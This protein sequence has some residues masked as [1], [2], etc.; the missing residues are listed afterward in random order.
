MHYRLI[1]RWGTW[2]CYSEWRPDQPHEDWSGSL[3]AHGGNLYNP[4]Q[5]L[6][7]GCWGAQHRVAVELPAPE[8]RSPLLEFERPVYGYK[9]LEGLRIDVEGDAETR[10]SFRS[11]ML[12]A[13]FR[14][15][16]IPSGDRLVYAAG[17]KYSCAQLVICR[18]E[19]EGIYWN[20][21][22]FAASGARDGRRRL[23]LGLPDMQGTFLPREL[24]HRES[25]WI[26][27][28]AEVSMPF[29]WE[30]DSAAVVTWRFTAAPW[31]PLSESATYENVRAC[32]S[33][34]V[35]LLTALDGEPL[36]HAELKAKYMRGAFSALEHVDELG[37]AGRPGPRTLAIRN[38]SED[39]VYLVLHG[40]TIEAPP[41]HWPTTRTHLPFRAEW[42]DGTRP[43]RDTAADVP[44]GGKGL[45]L[46]F[47]TN[48]MAAENGWIDAA[49]RY[50]A[51]TAAGN[52]VLFRT[53]SDR[54]FPSDWRRMFTACRENGIYFAVNVDTT[55]A[56]PEPG[57]PAF[58]L[59]DLIALAAELGG[60]RFV[61]MKHHELSLPL[62]AGRRGVDWPA[63][64][65]VA[66]AEQ[67][68]L[69]EVRAAYRTGDESVPR[70][71]GEAML[72][73]RY[74]YKAGVDL[75]LSETMTG[76]TSLLLAEARGAA[77]AYA[78]DFWGLHIACHVNTSPEDFRHERMYW[79]NLA[80]GYLSGA[81]LIEDEEGGLAKVHSFVSGPSDPLPAERQAST[82]RFFR[83]AAEHPRP[84]FPEVDIG[85]LY[86]RHE[87]IT[88][89]MSL[90]PQRPVR[91]W[92]GF[93]PAAPEWEYGRPERGWLLADVFLP[94]VWLC[95]VL[96]DA[97]TLRRWFAGT[98]H[99]QVDVVPIEADAA[100]LAA[101]RFLLMPG[102]HTMQEADM[103]TLAAWVN[104]GGTL[105]LGLAQLQVSDDRTTVIRDGAVRF[106]PA[107]AVERLCGL[108]I[109]GL[110]PAEAGTEVALNRRRFCLTHDEDGTPTLAN[111]TLGAASK[112][113]L[114][115]G[116]RPL[117]VEHRLG[118]GRVYTW[119]T[120]DYFGHGGLLPLV[121]AWLDDIAGS[122]DSSVRLTGGGGEVA[123]FVYPEGDGKRVYLVNTDWTVA[124][125]IKHCTVHAG[126]TSVDVDVEEGVV[127]EVEIL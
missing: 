4:R 35:K 6:Y 113:L 112:A 47:D 63:S 73:H 71:L 26:P 12:D 46:G 67:A 95:P 121:R 93:G 11:R 97:S 124:G 21:E 54:V 38:M 82:A 65:T 37:P 44:S 122:L 123:Y 72:A 119:A 13:D 120:S 60:D 86:G 9:G 43:A 110:E 61:G 36:S 108:G 77:R 116:D 29:L 105:V 114:H 1:L 115:A 14:L 19:D 94:G 96:R 34:F 91:V 2:L 118:K 30:P 48:M 45:T 111:V 56:I 68:Y 80:L 59:T 75:I 103:E 18:V 23:A 78:R 109:D 58:T 53:E 76:N 85:L 100:C 88:G 52:Y 127:A 24:H 117:L 126:A 101:Y 8:W 22:R 74:A 5:L 28:G 10:L 90:N 64:R 41:P 3:S 57:G 40:A 99:G 107:A 39:G 50:M 20:A 33:P 81:S 98:P 51:A 84:S 17:P 31:V 70:L 27:P 66:E 83:W 89:G 16:D 55:S 7:H 15:G 106:P 79:M 92:E 25:A 49:V 102:W 125:N 104:E 87:A 69:D 42:F 32:N 62:Y